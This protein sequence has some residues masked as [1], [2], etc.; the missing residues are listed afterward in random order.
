MLNF[1][2]NCRC[3]AYD[4]IPHAH[5]YNTIRPSRGIVPLPFPSPTRSAGRAPHNRAPALSPP[6]ASLRNS[7]L[8]RRMRQSPVGR[9]IHQAQGRLRSG[10]SRA[11]V[12]KRAAQDGASKLRRLHQSEACLTA[13]RIARKMRCTRTSSRRTKP[14]SNNPSR[15][16]AEL[17]G[18]GRS[19][20]LLPAVL[21]PPSAKA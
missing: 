17:S 6:R 1:L 15:F 5:I 19:T 18:W 13:G 2:R 10:A 14:S 16:R 8:Y 7:L 9:C 21:F 20:Y 4:G 3:Q 11:C 12:K